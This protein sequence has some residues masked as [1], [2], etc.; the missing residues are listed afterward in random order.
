MLCGMG[1]RR[2]SLPILS[3]SLLLG[4]AC[5]EPEP[6][7]APSRAGVHFSPAEYDAGDFFAIP[8]PSSLRVRDGVV[9]LS[10]LPAR[11]TNYLLRNFLP[12]FEDRL[13]AFSPNGAVLFVLEAEPAPG[14]LPSAT[15]STRPDSPVQL[16]NVEPGSPRFGERIPVESRFAPLGNS[17]QPDRTL[18]LL[19]VPGFVLAHDER[20]AAL[21]LRNLGPD[22][23]PA[24][25][26]ADLLSNP[27]LHPA[28]DFQTLLDAL[29]AL[30]I[31][32][33][34][35][36]AA[37]VYR[38]ADPTR[39][40]RLA[41]Q[42]VRRQARPEATGF[43]PDPYPYARCLTQETASFTLVQGKTR[44]PIFLRGKTPFTQP[45]EGVFAYGDD[46]FPGVQSWEEVPFTLSIP[47]GP[48]PAGGFP[49]VLYQHGAGGSRHSFVRDGT[50][51]S[52]ARRGVAGLGIDFILHS[53]RNPPPYHDTMFL[54][55]NPN[56]VPAALDVE[57]QAAVDLFTLARL[58]P[59]LR[60]PAGTIGNAEPIGFDTARVGYIGHSQGAFVGVPFL[61]FAEDVSAGIL[62]GS[63]GH[64]IT[65]ITDRIAG[66]SIDLQLYLGLEDADAIEDGVAVLLGIPGE[67]PDRFHFLFT[68]IQ[69]IADPVD[70]VNYARA[71]WRESAHPKHV[72]QSA[73]L[74]D[75]FDP[76]GVN[77]ALAVAL[78]VDLVAPV[79]IPYRNAELGG[80]AVLDGPVKGN[81]QA[82]GRA[83]TAVNTQFPAGDHWV[84]LSDVIARRQGTDF[85]ASAVTQPVPTFPA[86]CAWAAGGT[87]ACP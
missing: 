53:D 83:I 50:A 12:L 25:A 9:D 87:L 29:P 4:T 60:V 86:R 64:M 39:N 62:S 80:A 11:R 36:A 2:L 16:V 26:F 43:E 5:A 48:V 51:C 47:D 35:L 76:P 63:G 45:G 38:T 32:A 17:F 33:G 42:I 67:K 52:L 28:A 84:Y 22:V 79:A 7:D 34:D 65:F 20:Y 58:A 70:P 41:Q 85:M 57:N 10:A 40:V 8:F 77:E 44:V 71:V 73:G 15:D 55:V 61:A 72:Y 46:G 6:V 56:N 81:R 18:T 31:A 24:P 23:K 78:G 74:L 69:M 14:A 68:L 75:P 3:L 37:T 27:R 19:P 30:E 21:V 82:G 49:L 1:N 13:R 59:G 66:Q 54:L